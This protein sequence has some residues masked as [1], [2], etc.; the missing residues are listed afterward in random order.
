MRARSRQ[1]SLPI[2][3]VHPIEWLVTGPGGIIW[4]RDFRGHLMD[5]APDQIERYAYLPFGHGRL[6][7]AAGLAP[8]AAVAE[9]AEGSQHLNLREGL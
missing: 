4:D 6:H 2:V 7:G 1:S 8:M 5:A 3:F 9:P